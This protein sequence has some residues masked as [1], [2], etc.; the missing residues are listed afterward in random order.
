VESQRASWFGREYHKIMGLSQL[1]DLVLVQSTALM[2]LI[3]ILDLIS[4]I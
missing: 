2:P 1:V 4:E 3:F